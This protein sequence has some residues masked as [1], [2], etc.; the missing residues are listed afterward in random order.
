LDIHPAAITWRQGMMIRGPRSL[1]VR[2]A[3]QGGH[4]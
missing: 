4:D 1:P 3:G 2:F